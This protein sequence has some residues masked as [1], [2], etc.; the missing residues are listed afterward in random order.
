MGGGGGGGG[1]HRCRNTVCLNVCFQHCVCVWGGER[2]FPG[3]PLTVQVVWG[4]GE[5]R[6]SSPPHSVGVPC[7]CLLH[8][9]DIEHSIE[10]LNRLAC[11]RFKLIKLK[12]PHSKTIC[13]CDS[14]N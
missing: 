3:P 1:D 4:E 7:S 14:I 12:C 11:F 8:Y 5:G 13:I 10:P 2:E 6:S 9:I